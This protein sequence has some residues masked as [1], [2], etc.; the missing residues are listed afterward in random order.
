[1]KFYYNAL[2][3]ELQKN[4]METNNRK[5]AHLHILLVSTSDA[6]EFPP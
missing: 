1:M 5:E 4:A 2:Y 3:A 6:A